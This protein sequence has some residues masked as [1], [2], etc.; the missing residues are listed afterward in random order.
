MSNQIN[1]L[2]KG[3]RIYRVCEIGS[4]RPRFVIARSR[5]EAIRRVVENRFAA[6]PASQG[7]LLYAIQ[8]GLPVENI[9]P[10][11]AP[12]QEELL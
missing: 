7:D 6:E 12:E 3:A 11:A 10:G 9:G 5:A 1:D 2:P 8:N 4:D